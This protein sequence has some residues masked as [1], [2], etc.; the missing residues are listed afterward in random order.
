M[1]LLK[2][3]NGYGLK[4][5]PGQELWN[6]KRCR[7]DFMHDLWDPREDMIKFAEIKFVKSRKEF[8]SNVVIRLGDCLRWIET[9][10]RFSTQVEKS[11]EDLLK[12]S[13][14]QKNIKNE[15]D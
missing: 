13:F 6:L 1:I 7:D 3:L 4:I 12:S 15:M 2:K 11:F 5:K 14:S 9:V 10:R 8:S